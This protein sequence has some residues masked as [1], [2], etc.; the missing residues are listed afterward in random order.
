[1]IVVSSSHINNLIKQRRKQSMRCLIFDWHASQSFL[2]Q[3]HKERVRRCCPE[4]V[5]LI[6]LFFIIF[7]PNKMN[8]SNTIIVAWDVRDNMTLSLISKTIHKQ[9]W[10]QK[11]L[12][13]GPSVTLIYLSIQ[14]PCTY[15][16]TYAR[17]LIIYTHFLF[18]K[19][20]IYK[21]KKEFNI[22]N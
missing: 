16:Y 22:F 2:I 3:Q 4:S 6:A 5:V 12:F 11:F 14:L 20:Y 15:I 18:D 1:M 19:L 21:K 10:S 8:N 9:G 17:F 13:G 7:F